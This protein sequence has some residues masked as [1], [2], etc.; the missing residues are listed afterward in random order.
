[1]EGVARFFDASDTGL[2]ER[3]DQR[4]EYEADMAS[5]YSE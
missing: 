5:W 1:M 4:E 2:R 3:I